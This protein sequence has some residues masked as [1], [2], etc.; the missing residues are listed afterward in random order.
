MTRA[1]NAIA[2]TEVRVFE[3]YMGPAWSKFLMYEW[4]HVEM[5]RAFCLRP[6][7]VLYWNGILKGLLWHFWW[8]VTMIS[9]TCV[10]RGTCVSPMR[11]A[12]LWHNVTLKHKKFKNTKTQKICQL[13]NEIDVT[14]CDTMRHSNTS[15]T[16]KGFKFA[17]PSKDGEGTVGVPTCSICRITFLFCVFWV[18]TSGD[19]M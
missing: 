5:Y 15:V 9:V 19:K 7:A 8:H 13:E 12:T 10:T 14:P 16:P 6:T 4:Q 18:Y 2:H 11:C 17:G 3:S 1:A